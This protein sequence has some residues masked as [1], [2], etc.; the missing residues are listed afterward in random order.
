MSTPVESFMLA[1]L[2]IPNAVYRFGAEA[3]YADPWPGA[4]DCSEAIEWAASSIDPPVRPHVPDGSWIQW[5][6]CA[7]HHLTLSIAA[8][9]RIRGSLLFRFSSNPAI[10]GRP[11]GSHVAVALGDGTTIEAR[12]LSYGCGSWTAAPTIRGWTHAALLPGV[13]YARP[14]PSYRTLRYQL[15][16]MRGLDVAYVQQR[17]VAIGYAGTPALRPD[18]IFGPLTREAVR[19]FQY[20]SGLDA[21][22]IVGPLTWAALG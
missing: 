12:S 14:T 15:P 9:V 7:L 11:S 17:I 10:G 22:G 3:D 2:T 13:D 8:A 16:W 20:V 4:F 1:M 5:R 18:G 19:W 6:H 21:D